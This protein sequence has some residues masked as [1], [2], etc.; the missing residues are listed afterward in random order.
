[1]SM[2]SFGTFSWKR[3][4]PGTWELSNAELLCGIQEPDARLP[5]TPPKI[6]FMIFFSFQKGQQTFTSLFFGSASCV[7]KTTQRGQLAN[8][9]ILLKFFVDPFLQRHSRAT[10]QSRRPLRELF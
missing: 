2:P 5:A 9:G 1:M 3:P 6:L 7:Q 8:G 10:V 4:G